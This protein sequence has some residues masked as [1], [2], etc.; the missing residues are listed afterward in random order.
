VPQANHSRGYAAAKTMTNACD[1]NCMYAKPWA[2][3]RFFSGRS[4]VDF[5]R[6]NQNGIAGGEK[7]VKFHFTHLKL[8]KHP[9]FAENVIKNVKY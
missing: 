7:V 6:D 8:I 2:S 3:E 1:P 5:S 4:R 9:F